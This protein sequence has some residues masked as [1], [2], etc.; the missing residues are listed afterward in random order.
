[1]TLACAKRLFEPH[2]PAHRTARRL[3]LAR[4]VSRDPVINYLW[5]FGDGTT[6]SGVEPTHTYASAG[7]FTVKTVLFSGVGSAFPGAGAAPV[8]VERVTVGRR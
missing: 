8:V 6:G 3:R 7:T 1:V 5:E 4:A 2:F